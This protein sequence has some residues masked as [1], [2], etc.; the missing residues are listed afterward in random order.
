MAVE[1]S[2]RLMVYHMRSVDNMRPAS[3]SGEGKLAR[4]R[5]MLGRGTWDAAWQE[6]EGLG[7]R[8]ARAM[9]GEVRCI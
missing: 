2:T 1:G 7:R 9:R 8:E 6:G 4:L 5:F 3:R